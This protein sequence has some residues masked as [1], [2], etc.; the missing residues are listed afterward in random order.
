MSRF[1]D[2][3]YEEPLPN[4]FKALKR[5][6]NF[7]N[8]HILTGDDAQRLWNKPV[9]HQYQAGYPSPDNHPDSAFTCYHDSIDQRV[10][11]HRA[12]DCYHVRDGEE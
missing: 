3:Y 1:L 7:H 5:N 8:H 9:F 11:E 10:H 6:P 12:G 2:E 4:G